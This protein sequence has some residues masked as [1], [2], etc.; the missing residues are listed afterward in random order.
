MEQIVLSGWRRD[1]VP[2]IFGYEA[3][4]PGHSFGPAV[5]PYYLLHYVLEGEGEFLTEGETFRVGRGDLFVIRPGVV[6]TYRTGTATPWRYAWVGF[7]YPGEIPFLKAA[8][9]RQPPVRHIFSFIRDHQSEEGLDGKIYSMIHELLWLLD[10]EEGIG[11]RQHAAY[12]RK[13][14]DTAYM[15]TISIDSIA[16]QLHIDRR[17]LTRQFKA[18]Y[19]MPPQEY[20]MR[21]RLEKAA[22]FLE[23]GYSVSDSAC[24]AGFSDLPNFSRHFRRQYGVVPREYRQRKAE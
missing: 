17:Y 7:Y 15:Q 5:R 4:C 14:L 1:V 20:L 11:A 10:T 3:C 9:I 6:T 13:Y 8:V 2:N 18:S 21:L 12:T 22:L 16:R 23:Q 19:G 24:M